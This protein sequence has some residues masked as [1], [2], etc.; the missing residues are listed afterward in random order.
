MPTKWRT[1]RVFIS[2]TFRDMHAERDYLVRVVFPSLREKLL[3]YRLHLNDIDL[4][5]GVTKEQAENDQTLDLCLQQIDECRPFF[6]GILGERYGWVPAK[7][8]NL[9]KPEYGWIQGLTSKSITELE[10]LHGVLNN[11]KMHPHSIFFFRDPAFMTDVPQGAR[12][13]IAAEDPQAA[14]KLAQLKQRIRD[15]NLPITPL[16]NYLCRFAGL[17]LNWRIARLELEESDVRALEDVAADGLVTNEEYATLDEHLRGIVNREAVVYLEG[18]EEFGKAVYNRLWEAIKAEYELSA[19]DAKPG[20]GKKDEL[21]DELD[22]H[23]RFMESRLRVYVGREKVQQELCAFADGDQTVPG[24][25]TGP[26]GS[27]KSATLARFVADYTSYHPD[28]LVIPHFVG[29]SPGSTNLRMVLR[30]LCLTLQR[31]FA[32]T[33]TQEQEGQ[34]AEPV[35][36]AVPQTVN[37]LVPKFREF[38]GRVPERRRVVLA[39]DA[40]NQLDETDNAQSMYWL[41]REWPAHVKAILSYADDPERPEQALQAI[42]QRPHHRVAI[43]PLTDDERLKIVR[44]V[45]SLSAKTLSPSQVEL[46]LQ[47]PATESPL[48][49]L[50]AL[51]ELR[52]F[53]SYEQID[54]RIRLFPREGDTVTALFMQ[55]IERLEDEFGEELTRAVLTLLAS[56]RRGLSDLELLELIEGVGT[57]VEESTTGLF[58]VLRQLRPYLQHRAELLDFFHRNL[59]KAVHEQFLLDGAARSAAHAQLSK[60]FEEQDYFMESL[61]EQSA[62]AK[63]LPPTRRPANIRKVDEL[64]WQLL[65][66]AKLS[67]KDDPKSPHWDKVANLFTDIHFLEA[68]AEAV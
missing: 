33:E 54:S 66:V 1:V 9:N 31:E 26:S 6:V 20:E 58:P 64:P 11:P 17:R 3:P 60:Y 14:E 41:P 57:K 43:G 52:G 56:A 13:Q 16:E 27:G 28:V 29:A 61:E 7:L 45:P 2:S 48:F 46:L 55:V 63:R 32:F 25:V 44:E 18:L 8:P 23:E 68:K 36:A 24:L 5:W 15:T 39:I 30:R 35:P 59:Y 62:R 38:V 4:R 49:L 22:Y 10:I 19:A 50:V 65:Q 40:L 34:P 53:G 37:E 47:N 42:E 12:P 67:G 21:A 51:E